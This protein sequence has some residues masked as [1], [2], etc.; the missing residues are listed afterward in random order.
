MHQD[1]RKH[2]TLIHW[3]YLFLHA[4]K[5]LQTYMKIFSCCLF[6]FC[7]KRLTVGS[8][9]TLDWIINEVHRANNLPLG[10]VVS[11]GTII[12]K[13]CG[14]VLPG[15]VLILTNSII[16]KKHFLLMEFFLF[17]IAVLSMYKV[18]SDVVSK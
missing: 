12:G 11:K 1:K 7:P 2:S 14:K 10:K 9:F 4:S 13:C 6:F 16:M 8:T 5:Q 15:N 18:K 17:F 3:I